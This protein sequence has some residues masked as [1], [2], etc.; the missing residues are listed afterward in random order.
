MMHLTLVSILPSDAHKFRQRR[1]YA[2]EIKSAETEN[3]FESAV[4]DSATS[5]VEAPQKTS[6]EEGDA[7]RKKKKKNQKLS[8]FHKDIAIAETKK[9]EVAEQREREL[10]EREERRA[11]RSEKIRERERARSIHAKKTRGGQ[12]KLSNQIG[13]LLEKIQRDTPPKK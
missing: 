11:A 6:A 3:W 9:Q 2:R 4:F 5:H 10:T 1:V 8:R 12:P 7:L 13:L